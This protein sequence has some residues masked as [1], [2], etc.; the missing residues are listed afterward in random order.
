MHAIDCKSNSD[1]EEHGKS[2][3]SLSRPRWSGKLTSCATVCRS[4]VREAAARRRC[5]QHPRRCLR[6]GGRTERWRAS[7]CWRRSALG[8]PWRCLDSLRGAS[9]WA[10]PRLHVGSRSRGRTGAWRR[11]SDLRKERAL[12]HSHGI[13]PGRLRLVLSLSSCLHFD[14]SSRFERG[15]GCA[16]WVLEGAVASAEGE[17]CKESGLR[18]VRVVV[19]VEP[20]SQATSSA[21]VEVDALC[22]GLSCVFRIVGI[23]DACSSTRGAD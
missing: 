1:I 4:V 8:L 9:P 5:Q 15:E 23:R 2:R 12:S 17:V 11:R 7:P 21:H 16:G 18:W 6:G 19:V 22:C 13:I 10:R 14:R 20:P 3:P